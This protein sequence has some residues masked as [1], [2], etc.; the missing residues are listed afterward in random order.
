M[1]LKINIKYYEALKF[2]SLKVRLYL[3]TSEGWLAKT[4]V[5]KSEI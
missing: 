2:N 1:P 3:S 5:I 4:E